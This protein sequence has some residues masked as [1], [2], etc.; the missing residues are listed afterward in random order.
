MPSKAN[1]ATHAEL[2]YPSKDNSVATPGQ[3]EAPFE[4]DD[5]FTTEAMA[6]KIKLQPQTIRKRLS[7]TGSYYGLKP[8]RLPNR[9]LMWKADSVTKFLRAGG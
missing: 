1:K 4:C 9:R 3:H 5:Y 2:Q 7:Q 8:V 6:D